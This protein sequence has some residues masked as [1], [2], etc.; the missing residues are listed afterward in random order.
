MIKRTIIAMVLVIVL[1]SMLACSTH[2]HTVG[3]GPT[4]GEEITARQWYAI[5]GL[6]PI[7]EVNTNEMAAGA[8]NYEIKTEATLIDGII[9]M[10]AGMVTISCRSVTVTK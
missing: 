5:M 4:T 6:I 10:F 3:N 8:T 2:I 7:T 9:N 1:L